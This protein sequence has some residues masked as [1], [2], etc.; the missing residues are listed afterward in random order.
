MGMR[1][2]SERPADD[3]G[4]R[5]R[6]FM[7][8]D[9]LY[10]AFEARAGELECSVDWLIAEAMKR[11]LKSEKA[12]ASILKPLPP[13]TARMTPPP[14]PPRS[15]AKSSAVMPFVM[16]SL[17]PR[18]PPPPAPSRSIALRVGDVRALVGSDRF[19][20]GRSSKEAHFELRDPNVSRQHAM[21]ERTP[22]G[23]VVVDMASTNGVSVNGVRVT[24]AAIRAG[25]VIEIGPFAIAVETA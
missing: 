16:P 15:R 14:P 7:C 19:V 11:L 12:P 3:H 8:R 17:P 5:P 9:D 23:F 21:I 25:D 10:R 2:D 4:K 24:R 22:E 18:P 13:G 20:L 6:T 1:R